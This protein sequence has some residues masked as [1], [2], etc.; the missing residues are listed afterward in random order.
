[1]IGVSPAYFIS[2]RTKRFT[3]RDMAEG[4]GAVAE[5]GYTAFEPEVFFTE[6]LDDWVRQGA[7]QVAKAARDA[8]L[9]PSMFVAHCL[10]EAFCD[11]RTLESD[12][13]LDEMDKVLDICGHF[14]ETDV[15][16]VALMT[17]DPGSG[18]VTGQDYTRWQGWVMEKLGIMHEKVVASGRKLCVE[19]LP[20][21]VIGGI[22]GLLRIREQLGAPDLGLNFD[23]GH[24]HA[25]KENLELI[26]AKFAGTIYGVHLCDNFGRENMSLAPGKGD[27]DF[28]SLISSLKHNGF[29]GSWDVE[30]ICDP[31]LVSQEYAAGF[32]YISGLLT[33]SAL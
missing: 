33:D 11:P 1:M 17:F 7:A 21:A 5:L 19:I 9:T 23:T 12:L 2:S 28:A 32:E 13:G 22:D 10:Q 8:G 3:A 30:I 20:G 15:V 18:M 14:P 6:F 31:E 27:V 16:C 25:C 24:A 29:T 26:P 4:L